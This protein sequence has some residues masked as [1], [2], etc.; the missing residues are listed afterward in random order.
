MRAGRRALV[1]LSLSAAAA[2]AQAPNTDIYLAPLSRIGD[3]IVVGAPVN[4]THRPGYDNQPGFLADNRS[5]LYTVVAGGQADIWRYDIP[6]QRS[7]QVT[8]TPESEYSATPMPSGDRFSVIRVERDSTQRL[9][10]F[11]MDGSDPELILPALK[12]VGYHAWLDADRLVAYVLGSPS[13]LHV[14][15]R[16]GSDDQVRASDIGRSLNRLAFRAGYSYTKRDSL[17]VLWIIGDPL[18]RDGVTVLTR[19]APDNEYHTWTPDGILLTATAGKLVRWNA[20]IG[21]RSAWIPVA[22]LAR[23]VAKNISRLVVSPDG[24]W[25]AFVAEPV[26][27]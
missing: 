5:L 14:V 20:Q 11:A 23:G 9:W 2:G 7:V 10:S 4:V 24:Q 27:R 12:P 25:L 22:D 21:E 1:A 3:S 6:T 19:A 8:R 26:A 17:K 13:T 15:N 16:D 18:E